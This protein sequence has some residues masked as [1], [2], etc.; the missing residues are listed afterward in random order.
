MFKSLV[1]DQNYPPVIKMAQLLRYVKGNA[2]ETFSSHGV[3]G[4]N[5][6]SSWE[7]LK[8]FYENDRRWI[9]SQL[10][11]LF[12]FSFMS[13]KSYAEVRRLLSETFKSINALTSLGRSTKFWSDFIVFMLTKSMD[14]DTRIDWQE[15]WVDQLYTPASKESRPSLRIKH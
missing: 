12:A 9:E 14:R 3:S 1:H 2:L 7:L 6:N 4:E 11:A 8:L 5:Y 13:A 10:A 15:I